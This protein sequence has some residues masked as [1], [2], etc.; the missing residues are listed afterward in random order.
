[1]KEKSR[2]TLLNLL[3]LG[4]RQ[5]IWARFP[6][7]GRRSAGVQRGVTRRE[8]SVWLVSIEG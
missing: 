2:D 7:Y 1:M 6:F 4:V 3:W 5:E 8:R